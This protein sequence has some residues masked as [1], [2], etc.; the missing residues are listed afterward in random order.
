MH[1]LWRNPSSK[2]T[3]LLG[4][5][6]HPHHFITK[7]K[8]KHHRKLSNSIEVSKFIILA[9]ILKNKNGNTEVTLLDHSLSVVTNHNIL[10]GK[11]A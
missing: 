11:Y 3:V 10:H 8:D 4:H 9:I 6:L 2:F 7:E 1:R 5:S